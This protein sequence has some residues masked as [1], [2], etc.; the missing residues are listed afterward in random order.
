MSGII[1]KGP[2]PAALNPKI[3]CIIG[4]DEIAYKSKIMA[5]RI[6]PRVNSDRTLWKISM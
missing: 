6:N 3:D 1:A 5:K 2:R 4:L